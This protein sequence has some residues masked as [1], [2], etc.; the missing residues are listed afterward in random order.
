[1]TA[2]IMNQLAE[3]VVEGEDDLTEELAHKVLD[4]G[5]DPYDAIVNGLARGMEIVSD[6]YEKGEAFVPNLL[7]A[8]GA[9][10]SADSPNRI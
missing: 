1:M 8:S 5:I 7:L 4:E 10:N 6:Q 3:A 9:M 2:D